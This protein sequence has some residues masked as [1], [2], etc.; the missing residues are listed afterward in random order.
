MDAV[1]LRLRSNF[2]VMHLENFA[3]EFPWIIKTQLI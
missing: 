1:L 2:G 3:V